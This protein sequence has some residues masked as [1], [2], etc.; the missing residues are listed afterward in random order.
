MWFG[1][2]NTVCKDPAASIRV[3]ICPKY[4]LNSLLGNNDTFSKPHDI[5]LLKAVISV[6]LVSG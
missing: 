3:Q 4:G 2:G 6:P 5:T 1:I